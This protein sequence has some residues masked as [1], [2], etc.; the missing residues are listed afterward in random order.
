MSYKVLMTKVMF[1]FGSDS[2]P[3]YH[4]LIYDPEIRFD[5]TFDQNI[6]NS[7]PSKMRYFVK[8]MWFGNR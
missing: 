5:L 7:K 8:L 3:I 2:S 1:L 6:N 4:I